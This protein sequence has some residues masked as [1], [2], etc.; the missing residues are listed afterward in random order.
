M[1]ILR[2]LA[3]ALLVTSPAAAQTPP[4]STNTTNDPFPAPIPATEGVIKVRFA[5]FASIPDVDGEAARLMTL[6]DEPGTRRLFVSDM[7]GILYTLG[8]NGQ[9]VTK[10]LDLRDEAWGVS[11]QSQGSERGFQSFAFHPQFA[12]RGA[13]G[14]GKFYTYTDTSNTTPAA[15]F[16]PGGGNHTHDTVLLEWSAKTPSAATYD[17]GPPRELMRF[18]QPFPNHNGGHI[19]FNPLASDRDA[20]VGL[21]YVGVADGGSGGDPL[22]LAQNLNSAFGKI[23]RIDPLGKNSANG[24]YGIPASNPFAND[25]KA[26]TLSE[27]YAYGVRN[28]QRLFW[29]SKTSRMFI[30]DIGQ[31]IV[32]EISPVTAGANLGWND[33]EGSY[34]YVNRLVSTEHPRGDSKVTY[35]V[36]EYGQI[37]PLLQNNSAAIGGF[38]YRHP[39]IRQLNGLLIFGD[40]PSGEMFYVS[41]DKFPADGGQD[42]IRRILFDDNGETKTLLQL[43]QAKNVQQGKK[44]ATRA[45]LRF[46]LGPDGQVLI[47]NKRDGTIRVVVPDAGPKPTK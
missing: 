11:V 25:A 28:P 18:E 1:S 45:D 41:A 46:G 2:L 33:W 36:V 35:P 12:R 26:D 17:G 24:K 20:D 15:D 22:D 9:N 3:I 6:V 39:A 5:E 23:L 37:D 19:T 38:V 32:E 31:N 7:R 10:Y 29:D 30:S 34:A 16:T 21:L 40:N 14:F 42:A 13:P 47:L 4:N 8:Y 44:P 43:I 27:I